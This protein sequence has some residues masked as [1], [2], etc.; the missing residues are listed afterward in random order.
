MHIFISGVHSGTNPTPGIGLARC[1][2]QAFP[3]ARLTAVDYSRASSGL[4]WTDFDDCLVRPH[5]LEKPE[6]H[7]RFVAQKLA[8]GGLWLSGY[9]NEV[10]LLSRKI[11][12]R[13][14]ALPS[15]AALKVVEKPAAD[16]ARQ[17]GMFTAPYIRCADASD[18]ALQHFCRHHGWPIWV[19]GS[20]YDAA[21]IDS[22]YELIPE[23]QRM[24]RT[25]GGRS[26]LFLQSHIDGRD[27]T[28]AFA[29]FQGEL[30]GAVFMEKVDIT[31][32]GK[33]WTGRVS[34]L[35]KSLETR[36][37][38]ALKT[39]GWSGGGELEC[40]QDS[41]GRLFLIEVNPRFPAWIYGSTMAGLN[42]P[43][44]L[45]SA[46]SGVPAREPAIPLRPKLFTRAIT[47][48]DAHHARKVSFG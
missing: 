42:L 39:L 24:G 11:R 9:D 28:I 41:L 4:E 35:P 38:R 20:T 45:M 33:T 32:E 26:K 40:V 18:Q 47:E 22:V 14:L 15:P 12:N 27:V 16:F 5:W 17:M 29:A 19:K 23:M 21:S 46:V 31:A 3:D 1:M 34:P 37:R 6:Q 30:L 13:R 44:R 48:L 36:L 25:W 43:A 2:R 8:K 10:R 7:A